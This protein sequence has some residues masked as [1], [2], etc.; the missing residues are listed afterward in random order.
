MLTRRSFLEIGFKSAIVADSPLLFSQE[1]S[2][3]QPSG[4]DG[5]F[6]VGKRR[7]RWF[8]TTPDRRPFFSCALNHIDSSIL[9]Y[10]ENIGR[11]ESDYQNSQ[12]K[13]LSKSVG[14]NLRD[15]G[16]NSVGWVQEL[17]IDQR[18]HSPSFSLEEYEA[19]G[20]PYCHLLPFIDT[21]QWNPWSRNPDLKSD[22]F[23][24]WADYVARDACTRFKNQ[25]N[26]IG[27]FYSDCPTWAHDRRG[28]S[29]RGPMIAAELF[30]TPSGRR[31]AFELARHYYRTTHDAIRRYDRN[32]LILG[33]RYEANAL[34]PDEIV[35]AARGFVDVL[36]FQDFKD[37]VSTLSKWHA[38]TGLPVLWADG[39]RPIVVA[40]Q[41]GRYRMGSYKLNDGSWYRDVLRGL[42][43]NSGAIGAHL[44]GAY[45]RNRFRARGL[46][47]EQERPDVVNVP[48]IRDANLEQE[49]WARR[50]S[51]EE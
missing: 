18:P 43:E 7:G 23:S 24:D 28:T 19:L 4:A 47:D 39:A 16:F 26:L 41:S 14:P 21:Q 49:L 46:L 37:P 6:N 38:K 29:W 27:Y 48:L 42:R 35:G 15:W 2:A 1:P 31:E 32:H 12:I 40:D 5:F 30:G 10:P 11:W 8:F 50:F 36:C 22:E 25:R 34:L 20:L 13:W 33:D 44:C 51:G 9:R 3:T 17:S 45:I